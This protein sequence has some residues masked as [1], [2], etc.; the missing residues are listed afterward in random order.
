MLLKSL[1]SALKH[2]FAARAV[3]HVQHFEN[4]L[5]TTL[6]LQIKAPNVLVA[7][8]AE[9]V[10]LEEIWRLEKII[11]RFVATSELNRLVAT[12]HQAFLLSH[13][14][15]SVLQAALF[16][17]ERSKGAFH[18]GADA[19]GQVWKSAETTG[20]IPSQAELASVLLGLQAP[21][22][23]V[24][25]RH[26]TKSSHLPIN[27]NAIA[28][29]FIAETAAQK[30]FM[31]KDVTQVLVNLGGDL[32]HYGTEPIVVSIANPFTNADNA[33]PLEKITL[34]NQGLATSGGSHRGYTV[35]GTRVS[36]L[37]DPRTGLPV[38]Q[39]ISASVIA[40]DTM[41]ADVLATIFSVLAPSESLEIANSL[42]SIGCCLVSQN[43]I[44]RNQ[45][46]QTCQV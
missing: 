17:Q 44:I 42:P 4:V 14:L 43:Q 8:R 19:L 38:Q 10:L 6:E 45:F 13:E 37:L 41:T 20:L 30:A 24:G 26:A 33:L 2:I 18:L 11:S 16:W 27:L 1:P 21:I 36:H 12:Q 9:K 46:W 39:M 35:A 25:A 15:E 7:Q 34:R 29:G 31:V 23:E 22:L 28:K 40:P 3:Q 5:G 32:R